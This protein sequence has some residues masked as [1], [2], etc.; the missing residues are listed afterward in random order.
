MAE[1]TCKKDSEVKCKL[2]N[3]SCITLQFSVCS[4]VLILRPSELYPAQCYIM[5]MAFQHRI[6]SVFTMPS[7]MEVFILP[8]PHKTYAPLSQ[9]CIPPRIHQNESERELASDADGI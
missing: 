7:S 9:V 2:S 3:K 8:L 4:Q 5:H 6:P 1:Q